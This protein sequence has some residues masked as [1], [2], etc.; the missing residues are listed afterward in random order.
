MSLT[1]RTRHLLALL[2]LLPWLW[3]VVAI[4]TIQGVIAVMLW[5][6]DALEWLV[7]HVVDP[8]NTKISGR[9]MPD[10]EGE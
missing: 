7:D 9:T 6:V 4:Y 10:Y 8:I 5:A 2:W 3:I 1:A